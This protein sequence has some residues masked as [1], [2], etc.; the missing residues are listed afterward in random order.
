VNKYWGK[1]P[2]TGVYSQGCPINRNGDDLNGLHLEIERRNPRKI[3]RLS[4]FSRKAEA[5]LV[6]TWRTLIR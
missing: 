2:R 4:I 3:L 1:Q 6:A 5:E